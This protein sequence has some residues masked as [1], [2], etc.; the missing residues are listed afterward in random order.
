[1]KAVCMIH[2]DV[3]GEIEF[4]QDVPSDNVRVV[5][6]LRNLPRGN[7][8]MHIHEFGDVTNG[9]TSAGEHFNPHHRNHGGP[10]DAER[11]VGDLGNVYSCGS[12]T[13]AIIDMVDNVITLFGPHNVLGRS[14]VVHAMEDDYGKGDND[15]SKVTGN[16]GSRLGCGV[17]GLRS[18][19]LV[20]F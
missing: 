10:N 9:C 16:S 5:G 6:Y 19:R 17:I 3:E 14:L 15:L 20:P 7:H 12:G 2:G 11:H 18:Q 8:G 1:M 4:I 13:V